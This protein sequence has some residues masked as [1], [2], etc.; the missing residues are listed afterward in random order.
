MKRFVAAC[1]CFF[2][3]FTGGWTEAYGVDED[4]ED[5]C[6]DT[7]EEDESAYEE[8]YEQALGSLAWVVPEGFPNLADRDRNFIA[9][10][11]SILWPELREITLPASMDELT[12]FR[13][14]GELRD[15]YGNMYYVQNMGWYKDEIKP[16][17]EYYAPG[18]QLTKIY[19][20]PDHKTLCD[21]DG[22]V[23][24]KDK[25]RLIAFPPARGGSYT[26]P[27]GVEII[28]D[29]AFAYCDGLEKVALPQGV[30]YIGARA[31][32]CAGSLRSL[33]IPASVTRIN[34][35]A[36]EN[37]IALESLVLPPAVTVE[38]RALAYLFSLKSLFVG[39][40]V[41]MKET[42]LLRVPSGAVI[43]CPEESEASR[44]AA[45]AQLRQ[46]PVGGEPRRL[47][48]PWVLYENPAIVKED[49]E[50]LFQEDTVNI[51]QITGDMARVDYCGEEMTIPLSYLSLA[52]PYQGFERMMELRS[53]GKEEI[54]RTPDFQDETVKTNTDFFPI[55][56]RFGT[57]Y[58]VKYEGETYYA[59]AAEHYFAS[60]LITK[61]LAV[62]K[63]RVDFMDEQGEVLATFF[64][65]EQLVVDGEY[66]HIGGF[67]LPVAETEQGYVE[68]TSVGEESFTPGY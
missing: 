1:L 47:K 52:D 67:Y 12:F 40:N 10:E 59:P 26:V 7:Y 19:I 42:E 60:N 62:L 5:V 66:V 14:L 4:Y 34:K 58:V 11:N 48:S 24:S 25:T 39:E 41:Q 35:R 64:P 21:V 20:S 54:Y 23:F 2:L 53:Y 29:E 3:F 68:F 44:A 45:V 13:F 6:E 30:S 22:V 8:A 31:F 38:E 15:L 18:F 65:G 46:T 33:N 56:Q 27:D 9:G 51:L 32:Y 57:W 43:Y 36:F 63:E 37:C 49:Y 61:N 28:A 17:P 16:I 50:E 55:L